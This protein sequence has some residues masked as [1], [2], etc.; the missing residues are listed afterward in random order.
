MVRHIG[1][2]V[3]TAPAIDQAQLIAVHHEGSAD[4]MP[5][6]EGGKTFVTATDAGTLE[7]C[8]DCSGAGDNV[9]VWRRRGGDED[10]RRKQFSHG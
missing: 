10:V 1:M 5:T 3:V 7:T 4:T 9:R 6:N 8:G 2:K